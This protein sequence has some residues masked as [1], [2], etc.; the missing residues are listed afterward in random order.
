MR[1]KIRRSL[2]DESRMPTSKSTRPAPWA[3]AVVGSLLWGLGCG[4]KTELIRD[5]GERSA[6]GANF[7]LTQSGSTVISTQRGGASSKASGETGSS[8]GWLSG[9]STRASGV[10][11]ATFGGSGSALGGSGT[12]SRSSSVGGRGAFGGSRSTI[13]NGTALEGCPDNWAYNAT[14]LTI[15][16]ELS[17]FANR[18]EP[19]CAYSELASDYVLVWVVSEKGTYVVSTLGSESDTS[20]GVYTGFCGQDELL[21]NDDDAYLSRQSRLTIQASESEI[22]TLVVDGPPGAFQLRVNLADALI[23]QHLPSE[24][25]VEVKSSTV[26][27]LDTATSTCNGKI[28]SHDMTFL[29][30]APARGSYRFEISK[31]SFDA[32]LSLRSGGPGGEELACDLPL[33]GDTPSLVFALDAGETVAIVVDGMLGAS[34]DF[35]LRITRDTDSGGCCTVAR[36]RLGCFDP[37]VRQCVCDKRRECCTDLWGTACVTAVGELGCAAAC[38][39][40]L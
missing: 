8:G 33:L 30:K 24:V 32:V 39:L 27:R 20:L 19:S 16:G 28:S 40:I 7:T 15:T 26:E 35:N 17:Q 38:K 2:V 5:T 18:Y 37:V 11:G 22:Y 21:C 1:P 10:G 12:G 6:G 31:A 4:A 25:P 36:E 34:G 9:G 23:D 3:A 13:A 29:W 14:S